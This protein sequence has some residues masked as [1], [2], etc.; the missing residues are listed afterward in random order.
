MCVLNLSLALS[1]PRSLIYLSACLSF[2]LILFPSPD[3]GIRLFLNPFFLLPVVTSYFHMASLEILLRTP[4]SYIPLHPQLSLNH[5][6]SLTPRS[7]CFFYWPVSG[8]ESAA[9]SALKADISRERAKRVCRMRT[10]VDCNY[11]EEWGNSMWLK[12]QQLSGFK[13]SVFIL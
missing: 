5:N 10:T 8:D 1:V 11:N 9:K 6:T 7:D 12:W 4:F 3:L 13:S 2:T